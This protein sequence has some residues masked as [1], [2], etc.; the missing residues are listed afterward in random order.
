MKI[1]SAK[2][3]HV[4]QLIPLFNGY[5]MFYNQA[6]NPEAAELFLTERFKNK[7]SVI[8]IAIDDANN[9]LGFTQ[10]YPTF[11]SVSLQRSYILN[12]LFV[13]KKSRGIGVGESLMNHAKIFA[14]EK[15]SRG[16]T[17]ETDKNNPAQKLYE[18]LGWKKDTEVLHYT[19]EI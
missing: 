3:K 10:L 14:I 12:D 15:N 16:L 18:R 1:I 13:L 9:A 7:D 5:R 19:W 4:D 6:S 2:L 8:F 11:S 17:L